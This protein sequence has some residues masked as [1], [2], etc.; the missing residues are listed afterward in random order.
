MVPS[1]GYSGTPDVPLADGRGAVFGET[2]RFMAVAVLIGKGRR[3]VDRSPFM[4]ALRLAM[5][6]GRL[7]PFILQPSAFSLAC[8]RSLTVA[9]EAFRFLI[10]LRRTARFLVRL[11]APWLSRF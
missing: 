3:G 1:I 10:R 9:D 8:A 7:L 6:P 4:A 11:T 5:L 2:D